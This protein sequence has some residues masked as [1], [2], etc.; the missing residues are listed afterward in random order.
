MVID[1]ND[2]LLESIKKELL[3]TLHAAETRVVDMFE[4]GE[5]HGSDETLAFL[6][7]VENTLTMLG[8][9]AAASLCKAIFTAI[10]DS[11]SNGDIEDNTEIAASFLTLAQYVGRLSAE[12]SND[13]EINLE[14]RLLEEARRAL[15]K[16]V[17]ADYDVN[18]GYSLT[19]KQR[20]AIATEL[21]S[22]ASL[23]ITPETVFWQTLYKSASEMKKQVVSQE[24]YEFIWLVEQV[25]VLNVKGDIDT[26]GDP[27]KR[28]YSAYGKYLQSLVKQGDTLA[29]Y[30]QPYVNE[31]LNSLKQLARSVN[32]MRSG[33][34]PPSQRLFVPQDDDDTSLTVVFPISAETIETIAFLVKRELVSAKTLFEDAIKDNALDNIDTQ[35]Q[36][37]E[38]LSLPRAAFKLLAFRTGETLL[39]EA[40]EL[41]KA[42]S[43][44]ADWHA[45]FAENLILVEDA[46]WQLDY[47]ETG[48]LINPYDAAQKQKAHT[49]DMA[50]NATKIIAGQHSYSFFKKA[51]EKLIECFDTP[52]EID[53][54]DWA[55][56]IH[57]VRASFDVLG[58]KKLAEELAQAEQV[59]LFLVNQPASLKNKANASSYMDLLVG[60]EIIFE[61]LQSSLTVD[62]RALSLSSSSREK[63]S[64]GVKFN[65][66]QMADAEYLNYDADAH[67]T[68]E[69]PPKPQEDES[70][71]EEQTLPEDEALAE[72][73]EHDT[74]QDGQHDEAA[75]AVGGKGDGHGAGD[76]SPVL[77]SLTK[78]A[79]ADNSIESLS[80]DE[81]DED[82]LEVFLEEGQ[83]IATS[84]KSQLAE[85]ED[86]YFD[87]KLIGDIRRSFHTLKG[88]GRMVGLNAFGEFAWQY[89]ELFNK[90]VSEELQLNE[91][92]QEILLCANSLIDKTVNS[93]PFFEDREALLLAAAQVQ[94]V[95]EYLL[96][97]KALPDAAELAAAAA[98]TAGAGANAT[99]GG[100]GT[101]AGAA[102]GQGAGGIGDIS[103]LSPDMLEE[104]LDSLLEKKAREASDAIHGIAGHPALGA[105]A[106]APVGV[107]PAE[108]TD[109]P[110]TTQEKLAK[111]SQTAEL[112]SSLNDVQHDD[113]AAIFRAL[114]TINTSTFSD[115][116]QEL[117]NQLEKV[118]ELSQTSSSSLEQEH[119]RDIADAIKILSGEE[120]SDDDIVSIQEK[121]REIENEWR[122]QE[123]SL[124]DV[125]WV[126]NHVET[127]LQLFEDWEEDGFAKDMV[128]EN[129]RQNNIALE[130]ML[131][132]H[133]INDPIALSVRLAEFFIEAEQNYQ[134]CDTLEPA[135]ATSAKEALGVTRTMLSDMLDGVTFDAVKGAESLAALEDTL[136]RLKQRRKALE[137]KAALDAP[138]AAPVAPAPEAVPMGDDGASTTAAGV[139][140]QLASY[141]QQVAPKIEA[142][143]SYF[144]DWEYD[145]F[146]KTSAFQGLRKNA[147]ELKAESAAAEHVD[148]VFV[149]EA[150][151]ET[152]EQVA[153][154][155]R[156]PTSPEAHSV[157]SAIDDLARMHDDIKQGK[158]GEANQTILKNLMASVES[159]QAAVLEDALSQGGR[160]IHVEANAGGA[161]GQAQMPLPVQ[162]SVG[163]GAG[164]QGGSDDA[165]SLSAVPVASG[166][167][168]TPG[169]LAES[170]ENIKAQF[171]FDSLVKEDFEHDSAIDSLFDIEASLDAEAT[172]PWTWEALS[173]LENTINGMSKK[174]LEP[175]PHDLGR[176]KHALD[177]IEN[178]EDVSP[179]DAKK[180]NNSL[181]GLR[182]QLG[183]RQQRASIA[184]RFAEQAENELKATD[185]AFGNWRDVGYTPDENLSGLIGNLDEVGSRA[186]DSEYTEAE[187]LS[188]LVNA[189][190]TRIKDENVVPFDEVG[191]VVGQ[192]VA[193]ITEVSPQYHG[194]ALASEGLKQSL[195]EQQVVE[196]VGR[197]YEPAAE[198]TQALTDTLET[199]A[200]SAQ[201]TAT[202]ASQTVASQ[203]AESASAASPAAETGATAAP[204]AQAGEAL[205][206]GASPAAAATAAPQ[207]AAPASAPPVAG[208][209]E[210]PIT[211][212]AA[213]QALDAAAPRVAEATAPK[214]AE[215]AAPQIAE[216]TA[217]QLQ[218]E[219]AAGAPSASEA[220]APQLGAGLTSPDSLELPDLELAE[221]EMQV[222]EAA[223]ASHFA[224]VAAP[225]IAEAAAP[226]IAEVAAPRIAEAAAPK[227]VEAAAPRIAEVAASQ[228]AEATSEA[229]GHHGAEALAEELANAFEAPSPETT[230]HSLA[231][232]L[233]EGLAPESSTDELHL[234]PSKQ[235]FADEA[236]DYIQA[237]RS[238]F[239]DWERTGFT[240]EAPLQRLNDSVKGISEVSEQ[241]KFEDA[242]ALSGEMSE[243]LERVYDNVTV[244][245]EVTANTVNDAIEEFDRASTAIQH[246]DSTPGAQNI[247]SDILAKMR[248]I[249]AM[250]S[251]GEP[252][253]L[254]SEDYRDMLERRD[255]RVGENTA[256]AREIVAKALAS[257]MENG[258]DDSLSI[259]VDDEVSGDWDSSATMEAEGDDIGSGDFGDTEVGG[260]EAGDA[261]MSDDEM[262][263][264]AEMTLETSAYLPF[265]DEAEPAIYDS[266]AH[267]ESW[268]SSDFESDEELKSLSNAVSNI[269]DI[270][271]KHNFNSGVELGQAV[272]EIL[273]QV[274]DDVLKPNEETTEQVGEALNEFSRSAQAIK[275]N[276]DEQEISQDVVQNA[277]FIAEKNATMA[278]IEQEIASM[279]DVSPAG[280]MSFDTPIGAGA[281]IGGSGIGG[282]IGGGESAYIG[283]ARE[284]QPAIDYSRTHFDNWKAAD[285]EL[286]DEFEKLSDDVKDITEASEKY[287]FDSGSELGHSVSD[288]LSQVAEQGVRPD[289]ETT[290]RVEAAIGEFSRSAEAIQTNTEGQEI[291]TEVIY[292]TKAWFSE[293]LNDEG[294]A[295]GS[296]VMTQEMVIGGQPDI[297]PDAFDSSKVV[298]D[299]PEDFQL[300]DRNAFLDDE[301]DGEPEENFEEAFELHNDTFSSGSEEQV[302]AIKETPKLD[303]LDESEDFEE[304]E[305]LE[306]TAVIEEPAEFELDGD[307]ADDLDG[308]DE[309]ALSELTEVAEEPADTELEAALDESELF[310][311]PAAIDA[312]SEAELEALEEPES[313]DVSE[314]P[315]ELE[316]FEA[317]EELAAFE[318]AEELEET[319]VVEAPVEPEELEALE[320]AAGEELEASDELEA[321]EETAV[322]EEPAKPEQEAAP[323][324]IDDFDFELDLPVDIDDLSDI[325]D[326][327]TP[328]LD[329]LLGA[330]TAEESTPEDIAEET[331]VSLA[332]EDATTE[333]AVDEVDDDDDEEADDGDAVVEYDDD[334]E[335]DGLKHN[336]PNE[337]DGTILDI[338]LSEAKDII[339]N[340]SNSLSDWKADYDD[341][342][343]LQEMQRGLHTLKGGARMAELSV[344]GDLSHNIEMLLDNI[345]DGEIKDK[346]T[347]CQVLSNGLML[348]N[349]MVSMADNHQTIVESPEYYEELNKFLREQTG[350]SLELPAP[351]RKPKKKKKK[352][353]GDVPKAPSAPTKRDK[354]RSSYMLRVR[355]ELID[356]L[357][358]LVGEDVIARS[359]IE[360]HLSEHNFQLEELSRTVNRVSEQLR[361]LENETEAQILFRHD[362]E[363][364]EADADFDPLELDRFSEIQ[365][366]S[367][368]LAES[369]H[370][371]Q[372]IR[373]TLNDFVD[374]TRQILLDQ[375]NI[376]RE[377]QDGVLS[378]SLVRFDSVAP[379]IERLVEQVAAELGKEVVVQIYG[380]HND[381]ERNMLEDLIAGFEHTI[382]N[383]LA[384][385]IES[386]EERMRAGK[387]RKGRIRIAVRR[388]GA[389]IGFMIADDGRGANLEAIRNKA[390]RLNMLDESQ[391]N[392]KNY[393]LQLLFEPGF[394][395]QEQATQISGRGIGMDVLR[396]V[397]DAHQGTIDVESEEG[398]GM[399]TFIRM[400]FAMSITEAL[401]IRIGRYDYAVPVMAIEGVARLSR[402]IYEPFELGQETYYTY[403]QNRYKLESLIDFIDP[404]AEKISQPQ[405]VPVLLIRV[406][407]RRLALEVEDIFGRQ[408]VIIKSVNPQFTTLPGIIGATIL[409]NGQPVP[410]MEVT[411][412]ARHFL[413]FQE[414]GIDIR[415]IINPEVVEGASV[416]PRVLV[417]DDSITMRKV[418]TK[419]LSK[420]DIE[421][422]TAKDGLDAIDVIGD[423]TPD[424]ILLDIEMPRMDGFEFA[425]HIR[426]D[427]AISSVPIVMI[428]SRTG[429][430]HRERAEGIGVNDY[431][432]K[433]YSE[434]TLIASLETIL[435]K[436]LS[437]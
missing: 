64:A 225:R 406:G 241:A 170:V 361:R 27:Q 352:R 41:L 172:P 327:E 134:V 333:S 297:E 401:A 96:S 334:D 212:A 394:S 197:R 407:S 120:A 259:D 358:S 338:F 209:G 303:A 247:N 244:P 410:V 432:G 373:G 177:A 331:R 275:D 310:E 154:T 171:D 246:N 34:A 173:N 87:Q 437:K 260:I 76:F 165:L 106:G 65:A 404:Y 114:G 217:S 269:T 228:I 301:D 266:H 196:S 285:F 397:I 306:E 354:K 368:L 30:Q 47:L 321:L 158:K 413:N 23:K 206:A 372:S 17:D 130:R 216:E 80:P 353:D 57:E 49:K 110:Q 194:D 207:A 291:R 88:S 428:T 423:W 21:K 38:S 182:A 382:R 122:Q 192:A 28:I 139:D 140:P 84:L 290:D 89:E 22:V 339:K 400:P 198:E 95:R 346:D 1:I 294:S 340:N 271:K 336:D 25:A 137:A 210:T 337:L 341:L 276:A 83:G 183:E 293:F 123:V 417:V 248:Q 279:E 189:V 365:Q 124:N 236:E 144:E 378:A 307:D 128:F 50:A 26:D 263:D 18:R 176:I 90:A 408:E 112:I 435:G 265:A 12:N 174:G 179:Q 427:S 74:D 281:P 190:L 3:T 141:V 4:F 412:L 43:K 381:I 312:S 7:S 375:N 250:P 329:G 316:E 215:L 2:T 385:G 35:K 433:P 418:T 156:K 97:G 356:D 393:L 430:K 416:Q 309:F 118:A 219:M 325:P 280:G 357:T 178:S 292:S 39:D 286:N 318:Q 324:E 391:A 169:D 5:T 367:R 326:E 40:T 20:K 304:S 317:P 93:N 223:A 311:E 256:E 213:S 431:L 163:A 71:I 299:E 395:T 187:E 267:Y 51:R 102:G 258:I 62:A 253:T 101:G 75:G 69:E 425:T 254:E 302:A 249:N 108:A 229:L 127:A 48:S 366:L 387:P 70:E 420:Y 218:T 295:L 185:D 86:N 364:E 233:N 235:H 146:E 211:A 181:M 153:E 376:Q 221:D 359:R 138:K 175:S 402:E 389:E 63:L 283:Y 374:D 42:K 15:D 232:S 58:E 19:D 151:S 155:P 415:D 388:E 226:R 142:S 208:T 371:L 399:A 214:V 157:K 270:S 81:I 113:L 200:S 60:L 224:E 164:A 288:I 230:A 78:D 278:D 386:P 162:T 234:D 184:R 79:Q 129:L 351:K 268:K 32:A 61:Q 201:E 322:I 392:D 186:R 191:D 300:S 107:A 111:I 284:A 348:T 436:E 117:S 104:A 99:G 195:S 362:S 383:S 46:L 335:F 252:L 148:S 115:L 342:S 135:F 305:E 379:R 239:D 403:G 82:I 370:D 262:G 422:R 227:I 332:T 91:V 159:L 323:E 133:H 98:A 10:K 149:T 344:L 55:K 180:I 314:E 240:D 166:Y 419:I 109:K 9:P 100:Q 282:G 347:A 119:T 16:S 6:R 409:D 274:N 199:G 411:T 328:A 272:G 31:T 121:L 277:R 421:H 273:A 377:L 289:N 168:G 193:E 369:M 132:S 380:G 220:A 125:S 245:S 143:Q 308:L 54:M 202:A 363:V 56:N 150:I 14:A 396:D 330:E 126:L 131:V 243:T 59:Q 237:S 255:E 45:N 147:E 320:Q 261:E 72:Q 343:A 242:K 152:L 313:L 251:L 53:L 116:K 257:L 264:F 167:L 296:G 205:E 66:E 52:E 68:E 222:G 103:G 414:Q 94:S 136:R 161:G 13:S 145:Q 231:D 105:I 188:S 384:H 350:K 345:V 8:E 24:S 73:D 355:S 287:G 360:R 36:L 85:L 204:A 29:G 426:N 44:P 398:K 315:E 37:A 67:K 298:P 349:D 11:L 33:Y 92:T 405:G 77:D 390:R 319:A 429:E 203:A 434:E 238:H 424:V 160:G